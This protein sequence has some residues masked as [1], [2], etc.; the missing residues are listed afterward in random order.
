MD[1][2]KHSHYFLLLA[3]GA[4]CLIVYFIAEP[5][6]GSLVLAAV[7]AFI[8]QPIYQRFLHYLNGK[9]SMAA[10]ATTF[11]ATI[12]IIMPIVF[13]GTQIFKESSQLYRYMTNGGGA[14]EA[15]VQ[16]VV[17]QFRIT[18][19]IPPEL[20]IDLNQYAKYI[21]GLVV[22]NMS[23]LFSSFVKILLSVFVSLVAFYF[24]L[25]DGGRLKKYFIELSPL[26]DRDDE[27]IVS[28]LELS[29]SA[30]IKGNLTIGL[31]QG[32]L[33][34]IGF[35]IFG[36]PNA[37]LWGGVASVAAFIPGVGTSLV[38]APAVIFLFFTGNAFN[39]VGLLAWGSTAVGLIDNFLAPKLV[40]RGM[41]LHTLAVF[42]AV[43]GGI[44]FFGPLGIILGPLAVS[45]CLALIDIYFSLRNKIGEDRYE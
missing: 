25:K 14:F 30:V 21:L 13:L 40:G 26:N 8:F 35:T 34:G 43:L 27:F 22:K 3:L 24:F 5:F 42:I 9:E 7:F 41:K 44:T 45:V 39:S 33:T 16:N 6:L 11:L 19:S 12:I 38:I 29:V 32:L 4:S 31:I 28:Q 37:V 36:V 17:D 18:F 2:N 1:E 10:F 15:S 20:E 23:V